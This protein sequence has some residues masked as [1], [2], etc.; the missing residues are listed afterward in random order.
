MKAFVFFVGNL[1]ATVLSEC[2]EPS[3][4]FPVP[5]WSAGG[6]TLGP[7][8]DLLRDR[9][10][11]IVAD[12]RYDAASFSVQVTSQ[13]KD[14]WSH[15][16]TARKR[17]ESRPGVEKVDGDSLYRI[18]SISKTFTVLGLL[19]QHEAGTLDLDSSIAE[20]LPALTKPEGAIPWKDI[21]LRSLASQLSGIPRDW[22]QSDVLLAFDDPTE[23]GLPPATEEDRKALPQCDEYSGFMSACNSTDLYEWMQRNGKPLFA[24]NQQSTYSN[25]AFELVGLALEK[26]TNLTYEKYMDEAIFQPLDMVLTTLETPNDTHAV[27]P[28]GENYWGVNEGVQNPTGGIYS[29]TNDM[30]KYLRYILTHYNAIAKGVNWLF[31]ASWSTGM[32]SFYG[33][34]W[35][36]FRTDK[37]LQES[38]R[39]VTFVTKGGALPGYV[40]KITLLPEY[41]L[42][43]TIL[44]GCQDN[45]CD[46]LD[47]LQENVTISVVR[48][49]EEVVWAD[50]ESVYG[51][52]YAALDETLNSSISFSA[53][54]SRGL[55]LETF[56]SNGTD[57]VSDVVA[58]Y[59]VR[60]SRPWRTQLVPTLL[61]KDEDRHQGEIWRTAVAI[62]KQDGEARGVWDDDCTTDI[63][64]PMYAG[65]A[66]NEIVFW[67]E[68]D[69]VEMPAWKVKMKRKKQVSDEERLAVQE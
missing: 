54:P 26:A 19:Y 50:A 47:T 3:P 15:F 40:S 39:P 61:N 13:T 5:S 33:M 25:I 62:E 6:S 59:L 8:F 66:I 55:T 1:V 21:T 35:E 65:R 4:A 58:Q 68:D 57:I 12:P 48:A 20:Y 69:V 18:A 22:A 9:L 32:N 10:D 27:L 49:A 37:A 30:S 38:K 53:S 2:F 60:T 43:I 29:S 64:G 45:D 7:A 52:K 16:H 14:L 63:D 28:L 17:N 23:L 56:V 24:P 11:D 44:V 42:G 41:G 67:H 34:P 46:L 36:I 51:G 31:P